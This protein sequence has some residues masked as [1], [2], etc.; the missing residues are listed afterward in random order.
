[1]TTPNVKGAGVCKS[2]CAGV[3]TGNNYWLVLMKT[4]FFLWASSFVLLMGR[5]GQ[6]PTEEGIAMKTGRKSDPE[7]IV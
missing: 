6:C 5:V 2:A 3:E 4:T 7:T 1:M